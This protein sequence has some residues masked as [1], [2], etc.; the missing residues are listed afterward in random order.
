[1]KDHMEIEKRA[2]MLLAQLVAE[3]ECETNE[4]R[5]NVMMKMA[6]VCGVSM[7]R[8]VGHSEAVL[9]MQGT[10]DFILSIQ[11]IN[12]SKEAGL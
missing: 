8:V 3:A 12:K 11:A 1:M 9:R 7:C 2:V 4:D 6:S 10:T 5:A